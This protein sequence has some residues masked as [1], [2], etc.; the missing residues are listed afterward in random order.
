MSPL[1]VSGGLCFLPAPPPEIRTLPGAALG[2]G[3]SLPPRLATRE[4]PSRRARELRCRRREFSAADHLRESACRSAPHPDGPGGCAKSLV[5]HLA[6]LWHLKGTLLA[7]E[8]TGKLQAL[9]SWP[10]SFFPFFFFPPYLS[11]PLCF[12]QPWR[13]SRIDTLGAVGSRNAGVGGGGAGGGPLVGRG[14]HVQGL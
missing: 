8:D 1:L 2:P 13:S 11:R 4:R 5:S 12:Y 6:P 7:A 3:G 14:G 10:P 9:A